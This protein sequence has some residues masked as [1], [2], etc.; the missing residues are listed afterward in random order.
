MNVINFTG[1]LGNQMFY[2][3]LYR[4]FQEKNGKKS[5]KAN[6]SYYEK[7][8]VEFGLNKVFPITKHYLELDNGEKE[9]AY[10]RIKKISDFL[11]I[12]WMIYSKKLFF[13]EKEILKYDKEVLNLK[14]SILTGYWQSY[15]Y[16]ESI[17]NIIKKEFVFVISDEIN[18]VAKSLTQ[19]NHTL[20]SVHFRRGD[21]LQ[22]DDVYGGICDE[23]YY[24]KAIN[25]F[26]ERFEEPMFVLF[27]DDSEWVKEIIKKNNSNARFLCFEHS[28]FKEYHDWYDM[29]FMS[30]CNHNI[31]ANSTFSWWGAFLNK[32]EDKIVY[33]PSRWINGYSGAD[34]CPKEWIRG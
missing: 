27:S 30:V 1:G 29:Y 8:D 2:Y 5:V 6:L 11:H 18:R 31:I 33:A 16:F 7:S 14:N 12:N 34:I 26:L 13:S 15:K 28:L 20:V 21:Y 9:K 24:R 23:I 19:E 10:Y 25:Y 22:F 3:A 17:E 4:A 32:N